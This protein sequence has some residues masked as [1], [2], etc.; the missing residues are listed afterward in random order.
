MFL[1]G[2][3]TSLVRFQHQMEVPTII[4]KGQSRNHVPKAVKEIFPYR[5]IFLEMKMSSQRCRQ[6]LSFPLCT[7]LSDNVIFA[8]GRY[9]SCQITLESDQCPTNDFDKFR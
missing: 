2:E 5:L 8:G 3:K 4:H 1:N 6:D 9:L 7:H